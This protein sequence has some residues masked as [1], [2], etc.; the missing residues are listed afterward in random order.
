M[1]MKWRL[2][3]S[4]VSLFLLAGCANRMVQDESE[5]DAGVELATDEEI[6]TDRPRFIYA[7]EQG[8]DETGVLS[9]YLLP[10]KNQVEVEYVG[11]TEEDWWTYPAKLVFFTDLDEG[12]EFVYIDEEGEE[13]AKKFEILSESIVI[14]EEKNRYEW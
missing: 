10:D 13:V 12:V 6:L 1:K 7:G 14:D 2:F 11:D 8:S 4:L 3:T 5:S 9:Y